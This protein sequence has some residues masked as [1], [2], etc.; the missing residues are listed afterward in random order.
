MILRCAGGGRA[1]VINCGSINH[2]SLAD[3]ASSS[4]ES[5]NISGKQN[6]SGV[7][8]GSKICP[9]Q[10]ASNRFI[11]DLEIFFR[12]DEIHKYGVRFPDLTRAT[13]A[14]EYRLSLRRKSGILSNAPHPSRYARL[15]LAHGAR[16]ARKFKQSIPTRGAARKSGGIK[17]THRGRCLSLNLCL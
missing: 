1:A 17:S 3:G 8:P 16:D 10:A 5:Q 6:M 12:P 15:G 13:A 2:A 9:A 11:P 7:F 14:R 4:R